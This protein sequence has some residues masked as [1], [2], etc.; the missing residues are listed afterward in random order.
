MLGLFASTGLRQGRA[1]KREAALR[2]HHQQRATT[3]G[4]DGCGEAL[5][6][7]AP[8]QR[9]KMA[10][11]ASTIKPFARGG[12]SITRCHSQRRRA[13]ERTVCPSRRLFKPLAQL[14]LRH[15]ILEQPAQAD[16]PNYGRKR[17]TSLQRANL[18]G[19]MER[20]VVVAPMAPTST[21]FTYP[22]H[23]HHS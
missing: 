10:L 19:F 8:T 2:L 18:A 17:V 21:M 22:Q 4:A 7:L 14:W 15:E 13:H 16:V 3:H 6:Y 1:P 5:R 20:R 9:H 12:T 11:S 23:V